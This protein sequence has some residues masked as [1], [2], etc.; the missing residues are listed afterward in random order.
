MRIPTAASISTQRPRRRTSG[1]TGMNGGGKFLDRQRLIA[2][3]NLP[4]KF[5]QAIQSKSGGPIS[6]PMGER[7]FRGGGRA[8]GSGQGSSAGERATATPIR[9]PAS[10]DQ[11]GNSTRKS[12]L[13]SSGPQWRIKA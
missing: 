9:W 2:H 5:Q 3:G 13:A 4:I 1:D 8:S 12:S 6:E 11:A 10:C 7:L